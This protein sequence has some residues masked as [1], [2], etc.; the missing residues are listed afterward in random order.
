MMSTDLLNP[1]NNFPLYDTVKQ[2]M[3][4]MIKMLEMFAMAGVFVWLFIAIIGTTAY[5]ARKS[6]K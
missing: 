4:R 3:K 5:F 1:L 6:K 2:M